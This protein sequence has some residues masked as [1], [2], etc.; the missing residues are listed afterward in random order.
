[1]DR[2]P[3]QYSPCRPSSRYSIESPAGISPAHLW[4]SPGLYL[5]SGSRWIHSKASTNR[6]R[7]RRTFPLWAQDAWGSIGLFITLA[8]CSWCLSVRRRTRSPCEP[9]FGFGQAFRATD[10]ALAFEFGYSYTLPC[11]DYYSRKTWNCWTTQ[12]ASM[13]NLTTLSLWSRPPPHQARRQR[14]FAK[15]SQFPCCF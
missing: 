11:W 14:W 3:A 4:Y 9:R 5:P 8:S 6:H 15:P 2:S 7:C 12:A 13:S 1:M 10:L